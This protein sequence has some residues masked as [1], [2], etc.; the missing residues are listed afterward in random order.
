MGETLGGREEW[1]LRREAV[2]AFCEVTGKETGKGKGIGRGKESGRRP[3][4]KKKRM[5]DGIEMVI[6]HVW[7]TSTL[8][9]PGG[10]VFLLLGNRNCLLFDIFLFIFI[11][12]LFY[13]SN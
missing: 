8:P 12:F 11:Y 1:A 13:I 10:G 3:K 4:K 5:K 7:P 6:F 2:A 9:Y